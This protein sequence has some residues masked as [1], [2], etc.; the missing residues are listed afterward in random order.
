MSKEK[1][2]KREREKDAIPQQ[3]HQI[4]APAGKCIPGHQKRYP[5]L[6]L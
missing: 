2:R 1:K 6:K 4:L 5:K 3:S